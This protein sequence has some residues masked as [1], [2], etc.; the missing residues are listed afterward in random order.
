MADPFS[1]AAIIASV[2]SATVSYMGAQ[3]QA[4]AMDKQAESAEAWG[5]Y[6]GKVERNNARAQA[7]DLEFEA[8]V[9]DFNKRLTDRDTSFKLKSMRDRS[10]ELSAQATA[11]AAKRG[12][13]DYSFSD[14]L[15]S[16]DFLAEQQEAELLFQG[17]L[18]G[19]QQ[20]TQADLKRAMANRTIEIGKINSGLAISEGQ[21]TSVSLQ[22]QA[23]SVRTAG[24]GSAIGHL[25]QG[26]SPARDLFGTP[27]V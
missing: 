27:T 8:G 13:L 25:S 4:D 2:A 14:V 10:R 3:R 1:W 21:Q 17:S 20:G 7:Q 18:T 26:I 11:N 9:S 22:T 19:F 5:E 24:L 23:S 6:K 12:A 15:Q 16:E